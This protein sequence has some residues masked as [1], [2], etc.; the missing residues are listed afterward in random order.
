MNLNSLITEI[1]Q[2]AGLSEKQDGDIGAKMTYRAKFICT[3]CGYELAEV[4]NHK[5]RT[6]L[7][8]FIADGVG[9]LVFRGR[10]TCPRCC[11][12]RDFVSVP[13]SA[14]KLGIVES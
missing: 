8:L 7:S 1:A 4:L 13:M 6:A 5:R 14:I 12:G 11:A 3:Q 2:L 9:V 10:L